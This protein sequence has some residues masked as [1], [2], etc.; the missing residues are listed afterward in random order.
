M[1]VGRLGMPDVGG[2]YFTFSNENNDLIW[3]FLAECHRRGWI[4]RGPRHDA[5]V[6][7]LRHGAVADGDERGLPGSRGPGADGSAPARR[8]SRRVPPRVD[9][10]A[11]DARRERRGRRRSG[12]AVR[13]RAPGRGPVLAQPRD[14]QAGPAGPVPGPRGATGRGSR[15]LAVRGPV[16]RPPGDPRRVRDGGLRAPRRPWSEVGEEEGTGIVH[17]APGCG[18]EDYQL[19]TSLG[20]PVVGP[21][22][23]D[24]RYYAGFGWLSGR[25]APAITEAIIDALEQRGFFSTSSRTATATRTAGVAAR[26]CC[27]GSSTSGTSAW[28]RSTTGRATS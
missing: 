19:G 27:S 20:L 11:L 21:I 26:R 4:Y 3:G 25:E 13:P 14:A 9:D 15:R 8:P 23:E 1:V 22:D 16:R 28:A 12:A 2:S 24:G 5:V 18:A 10:D 7:A 6:P 17:I